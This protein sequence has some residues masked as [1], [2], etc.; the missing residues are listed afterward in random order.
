[1]RVR[2]GHRDKV[3]IAEHL[4]AFHRLCLAEVDRLQLSPVAGRAEHLRVEHARPDDVGGELVRP[5]HDLPAVGTA[6][7][8]AHHRPFLDAADLDVLRHVL[9]PGRAIVALGQV[10]IGELLIARRLPQGHE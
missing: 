3:A 9:T 5:G 7:R 10:G 8:A 1:M 6:Q 2:G 4:H